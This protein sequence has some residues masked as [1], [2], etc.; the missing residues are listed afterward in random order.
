[1]YLFSY[2]FFFWYWET[3]SCNTFFKEH[4]KDANILL[5]RNP[6]LL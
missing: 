2:S 4:L 1:L 5:Y 6:F 3:S